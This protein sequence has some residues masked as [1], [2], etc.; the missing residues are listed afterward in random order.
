[1]EEEEDQG[2]VRV[3]VDERALGA[4]LK[5]LVS[6]G[7]LRVHQGRWCLA[8]QAPTPSPDGEQEDDDNHPADEEEPPATSAR[9]RKKNK[10]VVYA[11][12]LPFSPLKLLFVIDCRLA[13]WVVCAE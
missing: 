4:A 1:M 6:R 7:M 10:K 11:P 13:M 8:P 12:T 2:Q 3:R 5:G 9:E